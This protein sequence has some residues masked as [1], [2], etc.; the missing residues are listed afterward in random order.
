MLAAVLILVQCML[1]I[2]HTYSG[3]SYA[4]D[5]GLEIL[6]QYSSWV[7]DRTAVKAQLSAEDIGRQLSAV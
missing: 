2:P 6:V 7:D 5:G 1:V 3:L 4:E